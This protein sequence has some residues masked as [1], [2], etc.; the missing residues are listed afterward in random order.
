MIV[1]ASASPVR[2]RLLREAGVTFETVSSGVDEARTK[3]RLLDAGATPG[4]IAA[5]LAAAKALAVSTK[6]P[7]DVVIGADQT[8][9]LD[10]QLLDKAGTMAEAEGHLRR[11]R[12]RTHVLRTA[13]AL[14]RTGQIV[15]TLTS[16]QR[17]TMRDFSDAFLQDYLARQGEALLTSV[18]CYHLEGMGAQLFDLLEG[19]YFAVLG[20]PLI[21]VLAAL[22]IHDELAR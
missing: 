18:G 14:G 21:E 11:L 19:D 15:W 16:S 10:G 5:E 17:L 4:A 3:M 9:D 8:L 2:A 1:L 13:T 7:A 20:L 22:R 12:G 6:R